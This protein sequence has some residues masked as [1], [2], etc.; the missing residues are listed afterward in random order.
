MVGR[1][2]ADVRP[3]APR[4][5]V[6]AGQQRGAELVQLVVEQDV[7]RVSHAD[8][9]RAMQRIGRDIERTVLARAVRWHLEDRVLLDGSR[10]VVF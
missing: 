4:L 3:R 2:V 7:A 5:L 10:T 8:E 9:V 1:R 6:L